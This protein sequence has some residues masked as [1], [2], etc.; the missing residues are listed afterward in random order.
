MHH[1][2][3]LSSFLADQL[4]EGICGLGVPV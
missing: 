2:R 3:S 1:A 4:A